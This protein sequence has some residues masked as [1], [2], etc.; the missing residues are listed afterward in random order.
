M[1]ICNKLSVFSGTSPSKEAVVVQ[2]LPNNLMPNFGPELSWLFFLVTKLLFPSKEAI[3]V[4][5]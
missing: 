4:N 1:G 5:R 3:P 2:F